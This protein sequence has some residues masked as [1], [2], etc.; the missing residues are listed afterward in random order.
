MVPTARVETERSEKRQ[1]PKWDDLDLQIVAIKSRKPAAKLREISEE[2]G[3]PISTVWDRIQVIRGSDWYRDAVARAQSLAPK[4]L[5][6]VEDAI[7]DKLNERGDGIAM[8]VLTGLG[9]LSA[10]QK[11]EIS[12]PDGKP[13]QL[14]GPVFVLPDNGS[15]PKESPGDEQPTDNG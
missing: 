4:A 8:G 12:G 6:R 7:D 1:D 11:H 9:V 3:A 13:I 2:T 5:E 10:K 14:T 15:A